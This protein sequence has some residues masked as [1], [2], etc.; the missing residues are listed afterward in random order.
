M[1][2]REGYLH[3]YLAASFVGVILALL[4]TVMAGAAIGS[5]GIFVALIIVLGL[6]LFI[7]AG[8][9]ASYLNFRFHKMGENVAMAGLSAGLFTAVVYTGNYS[10]PRHPRCNCEYTS[11]SKQ[12]HSMDSISCFRI[13]IHTSRRLH[14]GNVRTKTI[15]YAWNLQS[16]K[17]F[18]FASA[19]AT[20]KC[21][22][23]PNLSKTHDFC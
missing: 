9:T 14:I 7:P 16:C 23:L 2:N 5:W 19:P 6:F 1:S 12:F 21:A 13:H 18:K 20:N 15:C 11:C 3:D 17:D 10:N 4:N 8:F 22:S